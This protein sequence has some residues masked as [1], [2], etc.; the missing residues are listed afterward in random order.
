MR[1][2][3][4]R[5]V[6]WH[7]LRLSSTAQTSIKQPLP[8]G[9]AQQQRFRE[10]NL[11]GKVFAVTGGGRGLGLS[12]AE[13]LVEAGGEV[14]C[15]DLLPTPHA[16]FHAAQARASPDFGGGLH[17]TSLDVRNRPDTE[18]TLAAIAARRKRLDGVIAAAGINHVADALD[19]TDH[20]M[21]RIIDTNYKGVFH[22]ATAAGRQMRAHRTRGSVLLV[23]SM[24][25]LI[26]NKGMTSSIYNSSKAA[27]VQLGR[28]LA[29]EWAKVDAD[30][31]GGVR[32]N[33]LCPGHV[34]TPMAQMV[35][36]QDPATKEVWEAENMMGRLGRPEEFRGLA[37][38]MMSEGSS[39]MT[40]ATV[41]CDGG[42]TAW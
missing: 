14:H 40:G 42:H 32:V 5:P 35:I 33:T 38:L 25:G 7:S 10:F 1:S 8:K 37:L 31:N 24:S 36:D 17:Y 39:F 30:G 18:A 3:A 2:R 12:M 41:V 9:P 27:V 16:D 29:M 4:F 22:T 11:E 23:A 20:D 19:Y 6:V 21:A 26:A 13:A 15:L 28:S 34:V